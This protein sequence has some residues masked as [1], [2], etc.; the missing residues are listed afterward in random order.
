MIFFEFLKRRVSSLL[1]RFGYLAVRTSEFNEIQR[2][3]LTKNYLE[4]ISKLP[5]RDH[6]QAITAALN[7][8]SQLGQELFVLSQTGFAKEGFFV[9]FGATNGLDLSNTHLLEK[10]FNW[11]GILAEPARIWH[12]DLNSN[13]SS[14]IETLCVWKVTGET[15]TFNEARFPE[16]STIQDF[17]SLDMHHDS[18]KYGRTYQ[19]DTISLLDLLK[20]HN[21]PKV[22]DYLSLDTEGSELEILE[23]FDFDQYQIKVITVEHN[24]TENR[25]I[26]LDLLSQHGYKRKYEEYSQFDDWYILASE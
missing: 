18:R 19:V 7:C 20:K 21:A 5:P 22:I 4:L 9:E 25:S 2:N 6:T 11:Q 8:K 1:A 10:E 12:R 17:N 16:L 23:A 26:I 15:L 14:R 24:F 13:R 3:A